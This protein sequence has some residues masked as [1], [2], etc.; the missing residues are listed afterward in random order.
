MMAADTRI[1]TVVIDFFVMRAVPPNVA[2]QAR[3]G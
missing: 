2:A 3:R 1:A